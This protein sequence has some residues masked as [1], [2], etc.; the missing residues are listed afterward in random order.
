MKRKIDFILLS[1]FCLLVEG[2]DAKAIRASG[3][4]PS[5][6]YAC[7]QSSTGCAPDGGP[8]PP[9]VVHLKPG[10]IYVLPKGAMFSC[11]SSE[12]E[13]NLLRFP[14][15]KFGESRY[16]MC[17]PLEDKAGGSA[18]TTDKSSSKIE[19]NSKTR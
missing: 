15:G 1:I 18:S 9:T 19:R 16:W 3:V 13:P 8:C 2:V 12:R 17:P 7:P 10:T 5:G 4:C 14:S 6:S 11:E